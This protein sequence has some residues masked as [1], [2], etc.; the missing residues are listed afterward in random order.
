MSIINFLVYAHNDYLTL[1]DELSTLG[2]REISNHTT[3]LNSFWHQNN[4]IIHTQ[5]RATGPQGLVGFGLVT[6]KDTIDMS[7]AQYDDTS[8]WYKLICPQGLEIYLQTQ[9]GIESTLSSKYVTVANEVEVKTGPSKFSGLVINQTQ[10]VDLAF[11]E[12][13]G[14]K[15]TSSVDYTKLTS[16]NHFTIMIDNKG[17]TE[18]PTAIVECPELFRNVAGLV[19]TNFN[20]KQ[21]NIDY[22]RQDFGKLTH[23]IKGYNCVAHGNLES[24]T[25]EKM[26]LDTPT[27]MNTIL[28]QRKQ[29]VHINEHTLDLHYDRQPN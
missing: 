8:G 11:Y 28:R 17:L 15:T 12:R 5:D 21:Y 6:S 18:K 24:H 20:L 26:I 1:T 22:S 19:L 4:C 2:F 25:I 16:K 10:P 3:S 14:F 9:T 7:G 13:L 29:K 23:K 27:G